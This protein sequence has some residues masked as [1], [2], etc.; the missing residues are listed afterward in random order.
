MIWF[1]DL[2][3]PGILF[4][5]S[6]PRL[7]IS[8]YIEPNLDTPLDRQP[9]VKRLGVDRPI[10]P[11]VPPKHRVARPWPDRQR[12]LGA[13]HHLAPA[14][15]LGRPVDKDF[16]ELRAAAASAAVL[17]AVAAVREDGED[18]CHPVCAP[19]AG[20]GVQV[21]RVLLAGLVLGYLE[22]FDV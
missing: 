22:V 12:L 18:G 8:P 4:S 6:P 5:V 17:A 7:T 1:L 14:R 2:F 13:V 15:V 3:F 20:H 21:R 11:P 19:V 16:G 9:S 10:V